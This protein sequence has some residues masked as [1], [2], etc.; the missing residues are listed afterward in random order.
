MYYKIVHLTY[1]EVDK[2]DVKSLCE[3]LKS[4]GIDSLAE[5]SEADRECFL[6]LKWDDCVVKKK[7]TRR[8]GQKRKPINEIVKVEE[9]RDRLKREK[10]EQVA[11]SLGISKATLYRKLKRAEELGNEYLR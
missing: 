4:V 5:E 9:V 3:L 6:T 10:P 2:E 7:T 8:A 1:R 11:S